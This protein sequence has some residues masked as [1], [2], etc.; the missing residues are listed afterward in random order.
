MTVNEAISNVKNDLRL[1]HA[2]RR[3]T[4]KFI[5]SL[6]E[7]HAS[8]FLKRDSDKLQ[9]VKVD[10]IWQTLN[11]VETID[12][13][14]TDDC[15]KFTSKC[16]ILRTKDKLP[17]TFE[18][19]W[20]ILLRHVSSIDNSIDMHPI[21]MSEWT[22]KLETPSFKYD[23]TLYYFYRNGYLYFPNCKWKLVSITG[24]FKKDISHL[25]KCEDS[26]DESN[27]SCVSFLERE[28][29]VPGHLQS[30]IIDSVINELL[31]SFAKIP[32]EETEINKN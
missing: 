6:L 32:S 27:S 3:I 12:V 31:S 23:K 24:F 8:L 14:T 15:C 4:V 2:D 13:P 30:V 21:K 10:N 5:Y 11:C 7:K 29:R 22:R 16:R 17:E 19:S 28:W 26:S 18:D 20:G 25:N 1:V 9:L